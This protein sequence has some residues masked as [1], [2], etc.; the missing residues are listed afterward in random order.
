MAETELIYH[1]IVVF[2]YIYF[3]NSI[4]FRAARH[5]SPFYARLNQYKPS[6]TIHYILISAIYT[7]V[8]TLASFL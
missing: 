4:V 3:V 7:Y 8:R 1:K 5:L 6:D 2:D